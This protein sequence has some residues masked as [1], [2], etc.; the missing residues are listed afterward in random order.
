MENLDGYVREVISATETNEGND[1][2]LAI[3]MLLEELFQKGVKEGRGEVI[4]QI[5]NYTKRLKP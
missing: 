1:K 5:Q 2:F 4:E 3:Y